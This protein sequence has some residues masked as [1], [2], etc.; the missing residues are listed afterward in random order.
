MNVFFIGNDKQEFALVLFEDEGKYCVVETSKI[1][2]K[3]CG[4]PD[5]TFFMGNGEISYTSP[6]KADFMW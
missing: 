2:E 1:Q 3:Y 5:S 4:K 6:C